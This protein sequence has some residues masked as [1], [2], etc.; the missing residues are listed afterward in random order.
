[1]QGEVMRLFGLDIRRIKTLDREEEQRLKNVITAMDDTIV[2]TLDMISDHDLN[3]R[4]FVVKVYYSIE[5]IHTLIIL[6]EDNKK[7]VT[8]Q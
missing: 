7:G 8:Q 6:Y 1:M 4:E 3:D 5:T 2:S